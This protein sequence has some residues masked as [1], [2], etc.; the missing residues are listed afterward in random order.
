MSG[1]RE[2]MQMVQDFHKK[3]DIDF[4]MIVGEDEGACPELK[5][6]IGNLKAASVFFMDRFKK[7]SQ[8]VRLLRAHLLCEELA[9]V[10]QGMY[11]GN[12]QEVLDGLA[13][14][15]Y[16]LLGTAV[17]FDLPLEEAFLEVHKSNMTKEKQPKDADKARVRDKG[18]NY[19]APDLARVLR[20][21]REGVVKE[22]PKVPECIAYANS[23][24]TCARK[25]EGT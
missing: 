8:D 17:T 19:V 22:A 16:V 23:V 12:E 11:D 21:Y 3:L 7:V 4:K 10:F 1:I 6:T 9:E 20:E 13:D 2:A 15:L 25:L 18:P 5:A 24:I 14:L